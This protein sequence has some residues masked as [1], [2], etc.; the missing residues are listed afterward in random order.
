M[1]KNIINCQKPGAGQIAKACNNLALS[2]EMLAVSE[3]LSLGKQLGID[4]KVLA[5]IMKISTSR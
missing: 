2:I 5:D 4:I 3:A 1:G